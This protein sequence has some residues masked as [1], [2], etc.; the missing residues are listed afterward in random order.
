MRLSKQ[1]EGTIS[2]YRRLIDGYV[3]GLDRYTLT[4]VS[5]IVCS[6]YDGPILDLGFRAP[7]SSAMS[8]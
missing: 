4:K 2:N 3:A 8:A 6:G 1:V 7:S 5:A